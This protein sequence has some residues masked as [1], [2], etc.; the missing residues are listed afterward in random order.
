MQAIMQPKSC[1]LIATP[2]ILFIFGLFWDHKKYSLNTEIVH[3]NFSDWTSCICSVAVL[4][5]MQRNVLT[6]FAYN[7][8]IHYHTFIGPIYGIRFMCLVCLT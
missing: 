3:W 5:F 8:K 2:T 6:K 4:Y 1:Y 7:I